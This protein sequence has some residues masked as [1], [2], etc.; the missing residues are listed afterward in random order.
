MRK[1]VGNYANARP[2]RREK[3][4][5][6]ITI[7]KIDRD[8]DNCSLMASQIAGNVTTFCVSV[9]EI[10]REFCKFYVAERF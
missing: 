5:E 8:S 1:F 2:F 9:V 10:A 7:K 6:L 4:F 3:L